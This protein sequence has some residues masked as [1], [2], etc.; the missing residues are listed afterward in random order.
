V[1]LVEG[2]QYL[3]LQSAASVYLTGIKRAEL[4]LNKQPEPKCYASLPFVVYPTLHFLLNNFF[5]LYCTSAV[6][7]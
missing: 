3:L 1:L 7:N 6:N 2:L 5:H 4:Q